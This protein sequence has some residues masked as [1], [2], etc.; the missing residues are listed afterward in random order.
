MKFNE[1]YIGV[2]SGT[3]MDGV[4]TALVEITDNHV[5]LIAHD[6]YPMPAAMK[7]MLLSVC[8][9][10]TTN[11][12]AIGELDH[13]LGHLFAD[14]V[15]QLLNKSG[16]VA[17]QIRAIGNH[18]QTVFHQPTG[19]LPFTTQ[20][21]DA[22]IIAV[23][24]G[25]DTV[26][27]F[28]RKD[29]AL[30]GQG[31]PLVPAFHKSI[32][33]MQDSTTVVLNIGGIAN[34]SVLHPQQPVHGY[35]TGPGNMLM[36]AWC[37]RHTGH[38]FDKDAQL[39]L[40]GSVNEALLAHLL[41]EPYLAM[42]APKSTG[43]ELF[44]MDWLHHQLANYD[45]SVE[46]VQRTLCEYTA[47]TIAHDVTKFTYGETPQLLVC[48]GGARNP[49]LMQRLA[50]LLPQWHVT[51]TTD[52]GVDGDYMEAMAFAWLAQRHIHGLPS[53]LPEVTGASRLA[54][55]GVLYSKN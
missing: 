22:N 43:R 30:G 38:G 41:K 9:G 18:G 29:M 53:N 20:L 27:D 48:G 55:L 40:R 33:A 17:E 8:T 49:L 14:A 21:G 13:Q 37:E 25:I 32:F 3:S 19:E 7:E 45:V 54:S 46:D 36:D 51:T 11:L 4:D 23:K 47:I 31:A 39:A 42:S 12:K 44:N 5:R 24:T 52:K 15:L 28:R 26:A 34:I 16:Y 6:D 50:E 35:D 1:L 10:Q 2:M